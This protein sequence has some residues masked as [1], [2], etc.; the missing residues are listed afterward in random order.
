MR[1]G[2]IA[3]VAALALIVVTA[4]GTPAQ[5]AKRLTVSKTKGLDRA[6]ETVTVTGR[7]YDVEKGIYV[8]FCLDNGAGVLPS[9][10]G[11]GADM[12]G[13]SGA[14]VWISNNPPSY[15]EG[16]TKPYGKGGSFTVSLKVNQM[17]GDID[18][19]VRGCAIVT[20]ADHTRT[21][22]RSQDVRI[23]V[24]F[25]AAA[26]STTDGVTSTTA[27]Q[28]TPQNT[29][30][31]AKPNGSKT[32]VGPP[33]GRL[34]TA[35]PP[36]ATTAAAIAVAEPMLSRTSTATPMGHWWAIGGAFL[37]GILATTVMG[38]IRRRKQE[39]A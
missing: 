37:V 38:R 4:G 17:I 30:T 19:A 33:T 9:P 12:S 2:R 11:G 8:A 5:A 28:K 23:P 14:S 15:A 21:S 3:A 18:C 32:P 20:R 13:D 6:G 36:A 22:D 24:R 35:A 26:G 39:K 1:I 16:L 27:P 25:A 31:T 7:G 10:C 29:T 34:A